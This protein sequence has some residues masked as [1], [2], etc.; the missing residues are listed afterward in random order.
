MSLLSIIFWRPTVAWT[1]NA[2]YLNVLFFRND[3]AIGNAMEKFILLM[4]F[5]TNPAL[6]YNT[7]LGYRFESDTH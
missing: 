2:L 5:K 4:N 7:G 6:V 3:I 1:L